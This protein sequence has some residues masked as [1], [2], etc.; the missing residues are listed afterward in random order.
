M[1][2]PHN[3]QRFVDAQAPVFEQVCEELRA[4]R[5]RSHWMRFVFPQLRG[6]GHSAMADYFG[7]TSKAEALAYLQHPLLG[8]R[9][10]D[11][12]QLVLLV[13]HQTTDDIFGYPDALKFHSSMT[14]FARVDG[15]SGRFV[16]ALNKYFAGA[17]D[18]ATLERL[19]LQTVQT[20]L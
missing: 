16:A 18:P 4:G 10:R 9:L 7:I 2:D 12:T 6:L 20:G 13:E 8:P 1:N 14:L 15:D 11:C 5:K 19:R 3:L 17:P